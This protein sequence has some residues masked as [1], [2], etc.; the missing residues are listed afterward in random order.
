MVIVAVAIP[1]QQGR[2]FL[3]KKEAIKNLN[4]TSGKH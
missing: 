3:I 1:A 4:Y 2:I